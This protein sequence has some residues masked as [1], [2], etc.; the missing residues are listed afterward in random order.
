MRRVPI[1]IQQRCYNIRGSFAVLL[2]RSDSHQLTLSHSSHCHILRKN[3]YRTMNQGREM[4]ICLRPKRSMLQRQKRSRSRCMYFV[5]I[6]NF[7][8]LKTLLPCKNFISHHIC[9]VDIT[10][11][12]KSV[13]HLNFYFPSLFPCLG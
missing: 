2:V 6:L 9:D 4:G 8:M 7:Q 5:Y 13:T 3:D 10:D 1:V 12:S 11:H